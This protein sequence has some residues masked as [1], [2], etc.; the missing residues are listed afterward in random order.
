VPHPIFI[1]A[2][3]AIDDAVIGQAAPRL[4]SIWFSLLLAEMN[5][6]CATPRSLDRIEFIGGIGSCDRAPAEARAIKRRR[7]ARSRL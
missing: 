5:I 2:R 7:P 4:D 1:S 6:G 3:D